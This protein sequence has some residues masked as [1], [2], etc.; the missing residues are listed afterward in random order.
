M[1]KLS[2]LILTLAFILIYHS[3]CFADSR[4]IEIVKTE[5][6]SI[7]LDTETLTKDEE[8]NSFDCWVKYLYTN[9]GQQ[10]YKTGNVRFILFNNIFYPDRTY[11]EYS[12]VLYD[13]Y[14]NSIEK[15]SYSEDEL[16]NEVVVPNSPVEYVWKYLYKIKN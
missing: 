5:E 15:Y 1:K 3:I 6:I 11:T 7:Y 13:K 12:Y 14:G 8:D 10:L 4:Y 2:L 16:Q 9:K